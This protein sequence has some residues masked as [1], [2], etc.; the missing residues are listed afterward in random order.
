MTRKDLM[1][2]TIAKMK[3]IHGSKHFTFLP[4]TFVLP[5]EISYL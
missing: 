1:F 4:R 5:Q 3:E 2:K